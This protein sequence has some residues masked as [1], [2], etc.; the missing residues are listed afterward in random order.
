[1]VLLG[2]LTVLG[3]P[4]LL[5]LP[6]LVLGFPSPLLLLLLLLLLG[7]GAG[8]V[9]LIFGARPVFLLLL[10]LL[11]TLL[12]TPL[13]APFFLLLLLLL[14]LLLFL[15]FLLTLLSLLLP[16]PLPLSIPTPAP[17][18]LLTLLIL[19]HLP[20]PLLPRLLLPLHLILRML[21]MH[22]LH[23]LLL[24]GLRARL[25]MHII[26]EPP[27]LT[28]PIQ[29]LLTLRIPKVSHRRVLRIYLLP[30]KVPPV[31]IHDG[32]LRIVL[33]SVPHID[34]PHDV[35]P[36]V[37]HH[38]HLLD[39]PVLVHL[40]EH[41]LEE[42]LEFVEGS[43]GVVF[44]DGVPHGEGGF[45]GTVL[46]HVHQH[47]GLGD[48]GFVVDALATVAVP[49]CP[50]LDVEGAVHLVH[51]GSVDSSQSLSHESKRKLL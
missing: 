39:L 51:L 45:D 9:G 13:F 4:S 46:V 26:A 47:Y 43:L 22:L 16:F 24:H 20:L 10:F 50:H 28:T 3:P 6:F 37:I 32:I 21:Q 34:I 5:L 8:S 29:V 35:V 40:L 25:N 15:L 23:Q 7:S 1:M 19:P 2:S 44:P 12:F 11:L 49:A 14:L 48:G 36:Q 33:V 18:R 30:I 42:L 38:D 41:I 27:S 31:D 17:R